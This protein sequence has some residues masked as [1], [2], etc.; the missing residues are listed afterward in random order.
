MNLANGFEI[1]NTNYLLGIEMTRSQGERN[2]KR[3][4]WFKP[5]VTDVEQ[6][7]GT[8]NKVVGHNS[9]HQILIISA[10]ER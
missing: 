4:L 10:H 2:K 5:V 9:L 7:S 6:E 8:V 3:M 1:T